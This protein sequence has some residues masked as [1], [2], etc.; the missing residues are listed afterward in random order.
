MADPSASLGKLYNNSPPPGTCFMNHLALSLVVA[1]VAFAPGAVS[2]ADPAFLPDVAP[3]L[4]GRCAS[5]HGGV[6][7]RGDYKLHT[8]GDLLKPG[9][10]DAKPIVS[11]KPLESELYR[12]LVA[13]DPKERMP[14][15][16]D[17]LSAAEIATVKAW[18]TAGGTFD[19]KDSSAALKSILPPRK[20]PAPPEKYPATAPVFALAF[21]PDGKELAAGG[22]NEVTI[23]DS[24]TGKLRRRLPKLPARIHAIAYSADG[25]SL[26]VGG[27]TTGEYGEVCLADAQTG[28]RVRVFGTF[29]DVI[30][31][32]SFAADGKTLAAGSADRTT[33][34]YS[35]ADGAELWRSALHA[36]WITG[37]AFSP[38]GKWVATSSKDRTVKVLEAATGKLFTTYNGH[39]RQY[40]PHAGQFEVYGVA[41]DSTGTA[42]SVGGGAAVR[43]WDPVKTREENGSAADM[44]ERFKNAGHSRYLDFP[45]GK[46]A[47]ALTLG[48]GQVFTAGGDRAVRQ[49]AT[50]TGKLVREFTGHADWVY[51]LATHPGTERLASGAFDGEVRIWNTKTGDSVTTFTAAPG[52]T[53]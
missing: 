13:T 47:F 24:A 42:F 53:K 20:H 27:G 23:W 32:A 22:V 36:D 31:A 26:L 30:L 2:G 38:D 9:A 46:P 28:E 12:R 39:R 37:V 18:I 50:G 4:V 43:A 35:V 10:S 34:A 7:A 41:F 25:K 45:A 48:A 8:F 40:A 29:D 51:A 19:G 17:P 11:G 3:V 5:C 33:R 49:H 52:Y 6:K 44:E 21:S 16:D 14:P 15:G 1:V